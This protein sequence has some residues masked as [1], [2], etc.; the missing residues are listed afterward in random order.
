[1]PRLL[2]EAGMREEAEDAE[3]VVHAHDHDA[4]PCQVLPILPGLGGGPGLV[5]PAEDPDHHRQSLPRRLRGRPH[6]EVEAV[7]ARARVAED[8]VGI[9]VA[10]ASASD[11]TPSPANALP[12]RHGCGACQRSSPTGG[13]A[14][15]M[16]LK[17]RMPAAS[18]P[19]PSI[20][21]ESMRTWSPALA[22][23]RGSS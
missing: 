13:A 14:N 11:R 20:K 10:A 15:G 19:A 3:P 8:H 12:C 17:A 22:L 7:L 21:P 6:V 23:G 5:P 16:P 9:D 4:L 2:R 1:M 18:A